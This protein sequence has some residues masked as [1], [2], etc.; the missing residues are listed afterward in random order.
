MPSLTCS[1]VTA[2]HARIPVT[3]HDPS[4][5]V[6]SSG[7][8]RFESWLAKD[9]A[10]GRI[11]KEDAEAARARLKDIKGD[12]TDGHHLREDTDLVVEVRQCEVKSD[13]RR[14]QRYPI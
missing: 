4:A 9:L 14:F 11:S 5:S 6:L 7:V 3:I 13:H 10:K 8:K 1:Y 12:G 2:V